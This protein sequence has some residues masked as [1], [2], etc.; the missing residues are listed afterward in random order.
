KTVFRGGYGVFYERV[1]E[2]L[3]L[4]AIKLNGVNQQQF[5][6]INPDFFPLIPTADQLIEFAAPGTVYRLAEGLEAPYT[7]QAVFSVERQLPRNL[8]V[9]ASYINVRT[10]HVLRTRQ[11]N[12]PLPGTFTNNVPGSGV[13]P[14]VCAD[15]IPTSVNPS[16]RCNVFAYESS[17]IFNQNQFILNF[18]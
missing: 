12:A 9:A 1:G 15:Y 8:T 14:L 11:L 7:M 2:S 13:F 4:Q 3:T 17:G 16:T 5:T 10:L 6:V 18:Q